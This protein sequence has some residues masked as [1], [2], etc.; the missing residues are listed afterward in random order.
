VNRVARGVSRW[1]K[2]CAP[3]V[4]ARLSPRAR[5]IRAE[6]AW[7]IGGSV[8]R[9][10]AGNSAALHRHICVHHPE[11]RAYF[12]IDRDSPDVEAARQ[13]GPVLYREDVWTYVYGLPARVHVVSH[14]LHDVLTCSSWLSRRAFKVRLGHGLTALKRTT[15][16][17]LRSVRAKTRVFDLVPVSSEFESETSWSGGPRRR[18]WP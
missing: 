1:I 2:L 11:I 10:Y 3:W 9:A 8:G 7:L 12:V 13:V 17:A 4:I 15:G 14:G 18:G 5:E 16:S 6:G